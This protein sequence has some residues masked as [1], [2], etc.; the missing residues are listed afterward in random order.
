MFPD[1]VAAIATERAKSTQQTS[2][3]PLTYNRSGAA[4]D[5]RASLDAPALSAAG[6]DTSDIN[7]QNPASPQG[8]NDPG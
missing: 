6:G 5:N 7:G 2:A 1:T 3:N 4:P 8:S